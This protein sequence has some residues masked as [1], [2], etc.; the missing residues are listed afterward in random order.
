MKKIIDYYKTSLEQASLSEVNPTKNKS[1][2]ISFQD[3]LTGV[4][5]DLNEETIDRLFEEN[6]EEIDVFL[7]PIQLQSGSGKSEKRLYPLIIPASLTKNGELKHIAYGVPWIPRML[8][9]PVENSKLSVI[10]END[11]YLQF[12]ES[13]SFRELSW[14]EYTQLT[15][16][17]FEYVC[18]QK[19]TDFT[20]ISWFKKVDEDIL[21]FKG[22]SNGG[23][24]PTNCKTI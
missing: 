18:K 2:Q 14:N 5:K 7:F 9:A 6:E 11:D 10:G 3:Y 22:A 1:L 8:L 16:E 21:I 17:L 19:I 12:I 20:E 13:H 4:V 24:K 15:N 23:V